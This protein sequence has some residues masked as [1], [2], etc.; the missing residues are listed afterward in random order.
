MNEDANKAQSGTIEEGYDENAEFLTQPVNN[1][2]SPKSILESEMCTYNR[3][4]CS[5]SVTSLTVNFNKVTNLITATINI[6]QL[7][8]AKQK[9]VMK[10]KKM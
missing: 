9:G 4:N 1:K 10:L 5:H 2:R 6:V 3:K 8:H 7:F